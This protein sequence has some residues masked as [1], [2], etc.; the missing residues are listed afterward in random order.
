MITILGFR[1]TN[2]T[3][4]HIFLHCRGVKPVSCIFVHK[5]KN[6]N[7]KP[8]HHH[9]V[10]VSSSG[11][12]CGSKGYPKVVQ[13]SSGNHATV[14]QK[15]TKGHPKVIPKFIQK[16]SKSRL[17]ADPKVGQQSSQRTSKKSS[18]SIRSGRGEKWRERERRGRGSGGIGR[19]RFPMA[20]NLSMRRSSA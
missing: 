4:F 13:Q 17:K 16:A 20:V 12:G 11:H 10:R 8:S 5:T 1:R 14:V 6:K 15:S 18:Y 2:T 7:K 3:A 9:H 19:V